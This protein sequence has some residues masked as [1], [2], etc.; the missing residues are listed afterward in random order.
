LGLKLI[1]DKLLSCFAY[2]ANVRLYKMVHEHARKLV[3]KYTGEPWFQGTYT[4]KPRMSP[5]TMRAG[6]HWCGRVPGL[7]AHS[8]PVYP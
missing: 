8:V 1:Y 4:N 2:N 5:D 6:L 3:E 7:F